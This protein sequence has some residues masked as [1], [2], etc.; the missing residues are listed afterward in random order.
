MAFN[1]SGK[2]ENF[3]VLSGLKPVTSTMQ[4][5]LTVLDIVI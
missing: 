2:Y 5:I 1:A 3:L 4:T